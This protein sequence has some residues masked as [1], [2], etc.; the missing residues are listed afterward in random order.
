MKTTL[1]VF[2]ASFCLLA[3]ARAGTVIGQFQ[4]PSAARGVVN[5]TLTF[6]LSQTAVVSGTAMVVNSGNCWT[7][8]NG[9]VVGLPGDAAIAAPALS[10]NLGSGSLAG[11]TYYVRY[12]WANATG[13]SQASAERSQ[14]LGSTGT[15]VVQAPV[16][17]PAT[18]ASMRIYIG[19]AAGAESFQGS[20]PVTNGT[21][22]SAYNQATSLGAGAALPASN[23]SLCQV[24]FNDELQPS[25][26]GY[27]VIL[28]NLNGAVIPGFPQK[29]YLSGG[30]NGT[31]NVGSGLP[32]YSGVVVY[33]QPIV[34]N[35]AANSM[36]SINGPLNMNGFTI[37]NTTIT[38]PNGAVILPENTAPSGV[39]LSDILYGDPTAH[40]LKMINN[41]GATD[42]VV[43]TNT[44]DTLANKTL[45]TP[46]ISA[47]NNSGTLTL[48][49]STDT[50]VGRATTDILTNKTLD[51]GGAGNILKINGTQVNSVTGS[52]PV[53]V[54]ANSPQLTAPMIGASSGNTHTFVNQ[55]A[56]VNPPAGNIVIY[57]DSG[58][59]ALSCRNS[60]GNSCLSAS[61]AAPL[62]SGSANPAGSG[63]VRVASGDTAVAFRN[64]ANNGDIVGLTKDA[65]DVVQVGGPTGMK[66]NGGSALTTSNQSGTGSLCMT[67]NCSMTTPNI[68]SATATSVTT[69]DS[70][71]ATSGVV[72][73]AGNQA[74]AVARTPD[75]TTDIQ[76]GY[77][78]NGP[79][80]VFGS[81]GGSTSGVIVEVG[82]MKVDTGVQN[83]ASGIMHV[84]AASCTTSNA[85]NPASCNTTITWP[86]AWADTNYT[87]VCTA[88]QSGSAAP[89]GVIAVFG[90]TT[91]QISVS[92]QDSGGSA[93]TNGLI[94]CI[95][96]HD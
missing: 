25:Y 31:V 36:Q 69:T 2:L 44:T 12:T 16:N 79:L 18:A 95:G 51:T 9:S 96:M 13:E 17:V 73:C 30:S 54:L 86:G 48:P 24:R 29:W 60:S 94:H 80:A 47:I 61:A 66:I 71:A 55:A 41:N 72:R 15:L 89:F 5:G 33:P 49:A 19:V 57:G 91:T 88:D 50:L 37:L 70:N 32:V 78:L 67:T 56:P 77:A 6:A 59:G 3:P 38:N 58:S 85:T 64:S 76:L 27:N 21:L 4:T 1:F 82:K 74:C 92:I 35:P 46:A 26:T 34:S 8:T 43:G 52:G 75:N 45:T 63:I 62:V 93:A 83:N 87:A 42:F 68:G 20:V 53:V 90:K 65:S 81:I 7:D 11:G 84:R 28:T 39:P 10:S 22:A 40:R 14:T 23:S